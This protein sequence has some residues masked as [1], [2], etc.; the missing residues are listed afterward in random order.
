MRRRSAEEL[1]PAAR[2]MESVV[3]ECTTSISAPRRALSDI[4]LVQLLLQRC[5]AHFELGN[6]E[7]SRKDAL[8]ALS[9]T[10]DNHEAIFRGCEACV[11]LLRFREAVSILGAGASQA[12]K[13]NDGL[14]DFFGKRARSLGAWRLPPPLAGLE[15][16]PFTKPVDRLVSPAREAFVRRGEQPIFRWEDGGVF[17]HLE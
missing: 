3:A 15:A 6:F 7:A 1:W 12:P 10:P 16:E 4:K 13:G 17:F 14:F 5:Q 11:Q 8:A 2:L 9:I